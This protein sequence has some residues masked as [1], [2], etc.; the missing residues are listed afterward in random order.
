MK[1]ILIL[2]IACVLCVPSYS[3][4]P[5]PRVAKLRATH[6]RSARR[7][8]VSALSRQVNAAFRRRMRQ[9]PKT[10]SFPAT[11]LKRG[12]L[13][14]RGNIF[15]STF[16]LQ[17]TDSPFALPVSGFAIDLLNDGNVWGVTA[18]HAMRVITTRKR[19]PHI[20]VQ[21]GPNSYVISKIE[22]FYIGNPE[23]MDVALFEIPK[24]V[25]PYVTV[26]RPAEHT[27]VVGQEVTIR[28]YLEE[29]NRDPFTLS[30]QKILFSSPLKFFIKKTPTQSMRGFCGAPV[31]TDGLVSMIYIGFD[32]AGTLFFYDWFNK[33]SKE[34]QTT[35]ANV[36]Y[37]VSIDIAKMM[38]KSIKE[39][40][41]VTQDGLMMK[42]LGH[43]ID[44]LHPNESIYYI[45]QFRNGQSVQKITDI[46]RHFP[47]FPEQLDL[48]FDLQENDIL[49][50]ALDSYSGDHP[51][52]TVSTIY[53]VNVSTGQTTKLTPENLPDPSLVYLFKERRSS[54]AENK[55]ISQ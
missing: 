10:T 43:P 35:L 11:P 41:T 38:A 54:P 13:S 6:G 3:L 44:L 31:F 7:N 8:S 51:F 52:P 55:S 15:R 39:T 50:I 48:F 36:H 25:L 21:T 28:G 49:R 30:H 18:G 16:S 4:K 34:T 14:K 40:G 1:K 5:K 20:R 22:K 47:L 12:H 32:N 29:Q 46:D 33:L 9:I 2:L 23:G 19:R 17:H 26:L 24:E 42:V 37:A 53:D 27:P 45:E